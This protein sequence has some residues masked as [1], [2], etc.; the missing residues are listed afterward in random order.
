MNTIVKDN[1]TANPA[2]QPLSRRQIA[3][4][5]A[6]DIPEGW[7]VNLG[8]GAPLQVADYVPAEREV[9]FQSENGIL[10]MGPADPARGGGPV[11][12]EGF[13]QVSS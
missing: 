8:I 9:I 1:V 6:R 2:Y 12:P 3:E 4:R 10:G 13:S 7:Y 11:D 5:L